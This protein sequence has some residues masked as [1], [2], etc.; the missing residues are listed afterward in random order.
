MKGFG[1]SC[2][3]TQGKDDRRLTMKEAAS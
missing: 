3:N 2:E 1:Q